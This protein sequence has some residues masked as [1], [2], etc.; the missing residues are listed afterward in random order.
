MVFI[1][2]GFTSGGQEGSI[3]P[4]PPPPTTHTISFCLLG[5]KAERNTGWHECCLHFAGHSHALTLLSIYCVCPVICQ[6]TPIV[7]CAKQSWAI[8]KIAGTDPNEGRCSLYNRFCTIIYY[9]NNLE[10]MPILKNRPTHLKL[11]QKCFLSVQKTPTY[12]CCRTQGYVTRRMT[13]KGRDQL[14]LLHKQ[15][16]DKRDL[17]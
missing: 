17:P 3:C 8:F 4:P 11:L 9:R 12:L 13:N 16:H 5:Q 14:L 15:T 2:R 10:N 6:T 7:F 1:G